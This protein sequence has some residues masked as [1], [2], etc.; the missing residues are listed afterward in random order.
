MTRHIPVYVLTVLSSL[1]LSSR[2]APAIA[3]VDLLVQ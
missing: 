2:I 1:I 3:A